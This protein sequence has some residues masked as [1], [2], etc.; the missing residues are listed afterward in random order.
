MIDF[1]CQISALSLALI[2]LGIPVQTTPPESPIPESDY[3]TLVQTTA[4]TI[5]AVS[6]ADSS[7]IRIQ[8]DALAN[9][10]AAINVV[11]LADGS[12]LPV[13]SS[14]IVAALRADPP[15]LESLS[16]QTTALLDA[17][18]YWL[19]HHPSGNEL[20]RVSLASILARPEFQWQT[21][22]PPPNPLRDLMDRI[23]RAIYEFLRRVLP[24]GALPGG[25][26]PSNLFL[27][28]GS[29]L[30][31]LIL[32][33]ALRGLFGD[34]VQ[35]SE[36][37]ESGD[38]E[39][40]LLTSESALERAQQTAQAGDY[41]SAVRYLYLSTLLQLEERGLLRYDRART[42][43]EYLRSVAHRPDL[44]AILHD[45]VDVFDRTWYGFQSLDPAT[46]AQYENRVGELR[47]L[48]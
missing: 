4:N 47:R 26:I 44:A 12:Q 27:I 6:S 9:Q 33:L 13:D 24:A 8:L 30:L 11:E 41:R 25:R 46:Y 29:I 45:V 5:D 42:N 19:L 38:D 21:D 15:D 36:L 37:S 28:I 39:V 2:I 18:E 16:A 43:R 10:W 22:E 31:A 32:G 35:D 48:R 14:A 20:M 1:F 40:E 34:V 23:V 3:W 17:H 7:V